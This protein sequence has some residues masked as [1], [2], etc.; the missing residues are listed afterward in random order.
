MN[1]KVIIAVAAVLVVVIGII[2]A[3][4]IGKGNKVSDNA[5]TESVSENGVSE[6][7]TEPGSETGESESIV[8]DTNVPNSTIGHLNPDGQFE[9]NVVKSE[10]ILAEESSEND[11]YTWEYTVM[12]YEENDKI[13]FVGIYMNAKE[14]SDSADAEVVID[15]DTMTYT[16]DVVYRVGEDVERIS[17]EGDAES[18]NPVTETISEKN[19]SGF[20]EIVKDVIYKMFH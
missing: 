15:Y 1:K 16:C 10:R 20:D 3:V 8:I 9:Y 2:F 11:D 5:E 4:S 7:G 14:T 6:P 18:Y 12:S 13:Q 17:F 19:R